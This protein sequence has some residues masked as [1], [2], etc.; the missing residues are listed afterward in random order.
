MRI[1]EKYR[2]PVLFF[3]SL[4]LK[5]VSI[6][7]SMFCVWYLFSCIAPFFS[8]ESSA[9]SMELSLFTL[10]TTGLTK[11]SSEHFS[12]FMIGSSSMRFS[13]SFSTL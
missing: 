7:W 9:I 11:Y 10:I 5:S 13:C 2:L 8:F 3:N 4:F 12:N 1:L 6:R